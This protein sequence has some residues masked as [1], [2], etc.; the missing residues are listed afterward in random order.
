M[1]TEAQI[2]ETTYKAAYYA[3]SVNRIK[4]RA[5]KFSAKEFCASAETLTAARDRHELFLFKGTDNATS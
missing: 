4:F 5:G 2:A 1:T 3:H